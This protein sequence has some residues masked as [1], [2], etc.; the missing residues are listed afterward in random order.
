MQSTSKV[1]GGWGYFTYPHDTRVASPTLLRT[2][3]VLE[4]WGYVTCLKDCP[5]CPCPW[6]LPPFVPLKKEGPKAAWT[7]PKGSTLLVQPYCQ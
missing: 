3:N 2:S 6:M 1:L 5:S 4:G 7:V